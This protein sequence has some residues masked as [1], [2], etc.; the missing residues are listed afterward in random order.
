MSRFRARGRIAATL[1]CFTGGSK[2]LAREIQHK[3]GR[4]APPRHPPALLQ[5]PTFDR[6][7]SAGPTL[8]ESKR[9]LSSTLTEP[10]GSGRF[11]RPLPHS[12]ARSIERCAYW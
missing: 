11:L 3:D 6:T 5:D 10:S 7:P 2:P 4:R 8:E 12:P 1:E 9:Q